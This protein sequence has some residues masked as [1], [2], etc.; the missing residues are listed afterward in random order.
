MLILKNKNPK[1]RN[2]SKECCKINIMTII[3]KM[4]NEKKN[5]YFNLR[6]NFRNLKIY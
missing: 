3:V 1:A 6:Y 2:I 5:F 4:I